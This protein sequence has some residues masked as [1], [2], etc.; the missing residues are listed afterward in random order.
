M[1]RVGRIDSQI[2]NGQYPDI[3]LT[4][5][6]CEYCEIY[7]CGSRIINGKILCS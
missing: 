2:D 5:D 4:I 7:I 1:V 3:C 6:H